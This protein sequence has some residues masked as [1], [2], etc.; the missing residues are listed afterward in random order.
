MRRRLYRPGEAGARRQHNTGAREGQPNRKRSAGLYRGCFENYL[1]ERYARAYNRVNR[2]IGRF[3][4]KAGGMTNHRGEATRQRIMDVAEVLFARNGYDATGVAEICQAAGISKGTFY[5]H[6]S[7]K[8]ELFLDLFRRWLGRLGAQ[9]EAV[10]GDS[11]PVPDQLATMSQMIG[12]LSRTVGGKLGIFLE[13][14][15]QA[16]RNP[17]IWQATIEPYRAYRDTFARM[18]TGGVNEGSLRP[19]DPTAAAHVIVS[20]GVG[21]L[22]QALLDPQ[23]ADWDQ[24]AG[25]GVRILLGGLQ[26]KESQVDP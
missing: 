4:G 15:A 5:H 8:Q 21:L 3:T 16:A 14:W 26:S 20:L 2:P 23:G 24:V 6:F 1:T 25:E 7:G 17:E 9:I 10:L 18:V 13:F 11:S 19:V 12:E 22:L